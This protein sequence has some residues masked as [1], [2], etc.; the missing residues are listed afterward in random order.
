MKSIYIY[1]GL[2]DENKN[3]C[4]VNPYM[5][6]LYKSLSRYYKIVNLDKAGKYG[7][8]IDIFKYM[9]L[10]ID[11]IYFNWI[12]DIPLCKYGS[13]QFVLYYYNHKKYQ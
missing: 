8:F 12:E 2:F 11:Y 9:G 7:L 1:P 6:N 4:P 3:G 5:S 10:N 13:L